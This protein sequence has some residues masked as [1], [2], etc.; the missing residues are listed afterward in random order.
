MWIAQTI[1]GFVYAAMIVL[2]TFGLPE[3]KMNPTW[4]GHAELQ[5]VQA[6]CWGGFLCLLGLLI[7]VVP[8][9]QRELWAWWATVICGVGVLGG[10]VAPYIWLHRAL[11]RV[12]RIGIATLAALFTTGLAVARLALNE[13]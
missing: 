12:D 9:G 8:L 10:Y 1:L 13:V 6:A 3:H 11:P 7:A 4:A 2:F 5:L